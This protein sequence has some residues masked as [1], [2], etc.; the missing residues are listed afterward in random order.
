MSKSVRWTEKW[1]QRGLWLVAM[2]FAWFLTGL[3]SSVVEHLPRVEGTLDVSQFHEQPA[4]SRAQMRLEET[5]SAAR[6]ARNKLELTQYQQRQTADKVS[7]AEL[8]HK[9]WVATRTATGRSAQDAEVIERNREL[10]GL[11]AAADAA[12]AARNAA[13]AA[14]QSAVTAEEKASVALSDI[15]KRAEKA[16][17]VE[18]RKRD[19]RVFGYRL[20]VTL[21]LLALAAWLLVKRRRNRHWPFVWGFAIFAALTFFVELV[22]YLPEWAGFIR[23]AAGIAVT[24]VLGRHALRALDRY[25]ESQQATQRIPEAQ[26][27]QALEYDVVQARL[28]R[29]VCPGCERPVDLEPRTDSFCPHCALRLYQKCGKCGVPRLALNNYCDHCG[30]P[31]DTQPADTPATGAAA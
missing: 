5:R 9:A 17:A 24:V 1:M 21:P 22:P 20:A 4:Y 7:E 18:A 11:S 29:K 30:A 12:A 19:L 28:S 23:H 3:G 31:S 26:R 2:A 25:R 6:D 15:E 16:M 14:H 27:R 10:D 13:A 8:R